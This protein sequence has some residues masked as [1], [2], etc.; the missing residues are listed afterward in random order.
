VC[1]YFD[2]ESTV[3]FDWGMTEGSFSVGI[4]STFSL[5]ASLTIIET[6]IEELCLGGTISW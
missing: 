4:G 6:G 5:S 2:S 1:T 3:L